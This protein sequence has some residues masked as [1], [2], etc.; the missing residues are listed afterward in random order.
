MLGYVKSSLAWLQMVRLSPVVSVS[1]LL[2]ERVCAL[3]LLC[4]FAGCIEGT[5]PPNTSAVHLVGTPDTMFEKR[6]PLLDTTPPPLYD[7]PNRFTP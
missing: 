5:R 2:R 4:A 6:T 3:C 7:T 1:L